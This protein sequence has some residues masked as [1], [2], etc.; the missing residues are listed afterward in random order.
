MKNRRVDFVPIED[1][2]GGAGAGAGAG[3]GHHAP[4]RPG[5]AGP[6]A[7]PGTAAGGAGARASA[8]GAGRPPR[9]AASTRL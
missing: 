4:A 1:S 9:G 2:T 8:P 5:T 7:R 6:G 3:A